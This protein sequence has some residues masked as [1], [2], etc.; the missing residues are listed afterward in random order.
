MLWICRTPE[1]TP[2]ELSA[3]LP[4]LSP[5]RQQRIRALRHPAA[6]AELAAA[7]LLLRRALWCEYGMDALPEIALG[8]KGKPSLPARPGLQFNLS[9]CRLAVACALDTGPCGVDVQEYRR[10]GR[11]DAADTSLPAVFK[12]LSATERA[13][14]LA[15]D[16]TE[17]RDRRF[18]RI[19]TLKEAW[20]KARGLGVLYEL[21]Q[22]E[23]CPPGET[24]QAG[25]WVFQSLDMGEYALS[26]CARRSLPLRI[27]DDLI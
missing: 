17:E 25:E 22:T 9:H 8:P 2:D 23:L 18:V 13:W 7:E 26:V 11:R 24:W 6:A 20:G 5:A 27:V 14:V 3:C 4:R 19:W 15:A 16:T 10:L 21:D 12:V 1:L